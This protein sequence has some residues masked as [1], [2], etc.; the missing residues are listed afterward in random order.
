MADEK[1][2]NGEQQDNSSIGNVNQ[3]ADGSLDSNK[4]RA[5]FSLP[6]ASRY[7]SDSNP[8]GWEPYNNEAFVDEDG[9]FYVWGVDANGNKVK[10]SKTKELNDIITNLKD[11]GIIQ[12]AEA[13]RLD[14]KIYNFMFN[15]EKMVCR[16]NMELDF[17][18]EYKYYSIRKIETNPATGDYIYVTG[19]RD[20]VGGV[21]QEISHMANIIEVDGKMSPSPA[22]M[23]NTC[24][25]GKRYIVDFYDEAR[26]PIASKVFYAREVQALDYTMAPEMA[27]KDLVVTTDRPYKDGCFIYQNED[28]DNLIIRCGVLYAD[29]ATRDVTEERDT[30]RRL[31]YSGIDD[32][33]TSKLTP[34][35]GTPQI[36][37]IY[38]YMGAGD[39][40]SI[41]DDEKTLEELMND[42]NVI[43]LRKQ[44]KVYVTEDIY[45]AIID[46]TLQG[47]KKAVTTDTSNI[48]QMRLFAN[49]ASANMR[50]LTPV[51][52]NNRFQ[53]TAGFT[54]NKDTG[55]LEST[56]VLTTFVVTCKIPQGRGNSTFNKTFNCEFVE[57]NKRLNILKSVGG[58]DTKDTAKF[59]L[60]NS[61]DRKMRLLETES[62][63]NIQENYALK[64]ELD[65]G[66]YLKPTHCIVRSAM[67]P[68]VIYSGV[69]LVD[70]YAPLSNVNGV[71]SY[72]I[73]DNNLILEDM[74]LLVEFYHIIED[75]ES[76]ARTD[77]KLCKIQRT[78]AKPTSATLS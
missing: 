62:L 31:I 47:Y 4:H 9:I 72:S 35:D 38:Y 41:A 2:L 15:N 61:N 42:P 74:A 51:M 70:V 54:Y 73:P 46:L 32:I 36:I 78:Y 18:S 67:N 7:K 64:Y 33:D 16:L 19:I 6:T 40:Q 65:A 71:I 52:D 20:S 3:D 25:D 68:D 69:D 53:T 43:V 76:G 55:C 24:E 39:N 63:L 10:R 8:N 11:L 1:N 23:V 5:V 44:L 27:I 26:Y 77:I 12:N 58:F 48:Y 22:R 50:D 37:N 28:I 14:G 59:T 57:Y 34:G 49:Y 17:Y 60:F 21:Q 29:G 30:T 56:K 66:A 45:D 13:F 75:E